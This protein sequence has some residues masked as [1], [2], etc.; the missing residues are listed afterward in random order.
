MK[1]RKLPDPVQ[2]RKRILIVDD[3]AMIRE[4][5]ASLINRSPD[6]EVCGEAESAAMA[7]RLVKKLRPDMMVTD[8][9]LPERNG[10]ALIKDIH[11]FRHRLPVLVLSMHSESIYAERALQAGASGYLMKGEGAGNLVSV[12]RQIL[13]GHV[14]VSEHV[15]RQ[16][17]EHLTPKLSM[18]SSTHSHGLTDRELKVFELV[19]HGCEVVTM[20]QSLQLSPRTITI[21]QA[22]IRK[23][24]GLATGPALIHLAALWREAKEDQIQNA[25]PPMTPS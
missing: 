18:G 8:L 12:I 7:V 9:A 1:T 25:R 2:A 10:L 15:L 23:K 17:L 21:Y 22:N 11:A 6:L 16:V 13:S 20:A 4:G 19:G 3:H 5:I 24:L 14:M